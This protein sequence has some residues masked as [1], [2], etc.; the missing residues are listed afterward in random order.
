[1][2]VTVQSQMLKVVQRI[3]PYT[4]AGTELVLA[5]VGTVA[6]DTFTAQRQL[7]FYNEARFFLFGALRGRKSNAEMCDILNQSIIK[8]TDLTFA[9]GAAS[10]PTGYIEKVLLQNVSLTN[11]PIVQLNA[12]PA[13]S[14]LESAT[15]PFVYET[16]DQFIA[17]SGS[18]YVPNAAT[19]I[20]HYF[21]IT[22]FTL[23][24][25]TGGAVTETFNDM[26]QEILIALAVGCAKEQGATAL[27]AM[28]DAFFGK[29][30]S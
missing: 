24:N 4:K 21:G 25:V 9:S 17:P 6:G 10:K 13:I 23:A 26:W 7:D 27:N 28:V 1:M 29:I 22:N 30:G 8:K 11:I 3:D 14:D 12:V 16:G 2:S 19:Y 5:T 18:A 15:N 20:L